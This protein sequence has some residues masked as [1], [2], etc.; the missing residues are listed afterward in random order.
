VSGLFIA[1]P[2]YGGMCHG[3]YA[4]SLAQ[5]M[6]VFMNHHIPLRFTYT[7]NESIITR[8]RNNLTRDFLETDCTHMMFIDSDIGW[9]AEDIIRMLDDDKDILA[10][11]YPFKEIAWDQVAGAV[12]AGVPP[13]ELHKYASPL[14][15]GVD[16]HANNLTIWPRGESVEIPCAGA[17]FMMI[18]RGVFEGL[19]DVVPEYNDVLGSPRSITDGVTHNK[20]AKTVKMYFETSI[21]EFSDNHLLSEDYHFCKLARNH[22][23]KIWAAP[24]AA[25]THTGSYQFTARYTGVG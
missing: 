11:L 12:H 4:V 22:G 25:L 9:R 8:A 3:S 14:V 1:T 15:F 23:Y 13:E 24:W 2:M 6:S 21:D 5:T 19:A 16:K 20:T 10:G 18:K 17:G 7:F